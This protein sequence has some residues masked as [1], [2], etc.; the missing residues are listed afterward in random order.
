M[1][2]I[3]LLIISTIYLSITAC[4]QGYKIEV[5]FHDLKD[6]SIMLGYHFGE[7]KFVV[8]TAQVNSKGIAVFEGDSLLPGG[9]Y[10]VI[11][12]QRSYFDILLSNNQKFS[13]STSTEKL[14]EDLSFSGSPENTA[15]LNYQLFMNEKQ[16]KM[17]ELRNQMQTVEGNAELEKKIVD[18]INALDAEVK[19]NWDKV[20]KDNPNTFIANIIKSL[21]PIEFPEF[22][23]PKH[24]SNPDSLRWVKSYQFNQRHFFDNIDLTD[25]RLIRTPFFQSRVDAYFDRVL[26]PIADTI[27]FY[28]DRLINKASGNNRMYQ[29]L[30]SHL[31]S[32]YQNS[33]IMGMDAVFVHIAEKYYLTGKVD[34]IND[35]LKSRI[36][37]RVADLKPNLI[38]KIAPNISMTDFNN[39]THELHKVKAKITIVYFWEPNC[40]HCKKVTPQLSDLYKKYK[41]QGLEVF[42]VYTQGET[43]SWKEYVTKNGLNWINVWDPFRVSQ[44]HK[45]YDIYSTPIIYVLD[46]DKR[47]VAKRIGIESL[48]RFIEEE[49]KR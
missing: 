39:K 49:L 25:D 5:K 37:D 36:A 28:G 12:P 38:G 23:I 19:L 1:K 15:F 30:I 6:A 8:D 11:L 46:K 27:I 45:L 21:K 17:G 24:V 10:I 22:E 16:K 40:S 13:L 48:E 47:I 4:A 29:F 42:A 2:R 20:I 31:F 3:A 33:S 14:L 41:N 26:L 18:E 32:K 9:M 34:G 44:Y 7:K 35:G 43:D